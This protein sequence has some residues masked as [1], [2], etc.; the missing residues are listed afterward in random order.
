MIDFEKIK[1]TIKGKATFT[2]KQ[3]FDLLNKVKQ[4]LVN[5]L[6]GSGRVINIGKVYKPQSIQKYDVITNFVCNSVHPCLVYWADEIYVYSVS[7]TTTEAPHNIHKFNGSRLFPSSYLT[8]TIIR[9]LKEDALQQFVGIFDNKD[10]ADVGFAKVKL[11]YK[12]IF[13]L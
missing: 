3:V 13:N 6:E 1:D 2:Q 12:D 4:E 7:M 5:G 9:S 11:L 10:E 8:N